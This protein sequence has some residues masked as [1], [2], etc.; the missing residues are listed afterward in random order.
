MTLAAYKTAMA[1]LVPGPHPLDGGEIADA[2][3]RAISRGMARH[4]DVKPRTVVE[5]IAGDGGSRYALTLLADWDAGFSGVLAI[6]YPAD[7]DPVQV[8]DENDWSIYEAP[9][10]QYL[11]LI[12]WAAAAGE[13]IRVRYTAPHSCTADACTVPSAVEAPVQALCAAYYAQALAALYAHSQDSTISADSVD[14]QSKR[15]EFAAIAKGY[16]L[17]YERAFNVRSGPRPATVVQDLDP[18]A[19]HGG[20]RLTHPRRWR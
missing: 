11:W 19:S 13:S 1:E 15:R 10:V 3:E 14:Q 17:D 20:D 5:D 12:R 4:S 8:V 16:L 6:E 18:M 2:Q 9:A 7:A